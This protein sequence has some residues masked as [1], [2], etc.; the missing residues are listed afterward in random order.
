M[1]TVEEGLRQLA[2]SIDGT[3][4]CVEI[5]LLRFGREVVREP[6]CGSF[7]FLAVYERS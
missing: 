7:G 6:I 5:V 1:A 4:D 3:V 2:P